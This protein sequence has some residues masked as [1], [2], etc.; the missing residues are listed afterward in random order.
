MTTSLKLIFAYSFSVLTIFLVGGGSCVKRESD[1]VSSK[2]PGN[3]TI[4]GQ[5]TTLAGSKGIANH[6]CY[7]YWV[8]DDK[9]V[10]R[11]KNSFQTDSN[12]FYEASI[13][14]RKSENNI[15][16]IMLTLVNTENY[17]WVF[18]PTAPELSKYFYFGKIRIGDVIENSPFEIHT[19]SYLEINF[20][21]L[22]PINTNTESYEVR[23][24]ST[25]NSLFTN[26]F[27]HFNKNQKAKTAVPAG[28]NLQVEIGIYSGNT[29]TPYQTLQIS[30]LSPNEVR[31]I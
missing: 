9:K 28:M 31:N 27:N 29:F 15:G 1:I 10:I 19:A 11:F 22:P 18:D 7:V 2:M 13:Y 4:K 6:T 16:Y 17:L 21:Q 20:S 3:T 26:R 14:L 8:S 23:I 24:K 5:L 25:D 30:A 12:G